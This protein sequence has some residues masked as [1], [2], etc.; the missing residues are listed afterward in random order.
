VRASTLAASGGAHGR[1]KN[2]TPRFSEGRRAAGA[3]GR[4]HGDGPD[5]LQREETDGQ[6]AAAAAEPEVWLT[7]NATEAEFIKA[8]VRHLIPADD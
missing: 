4:R 7:L 8:A 2:P 6:A 5:G 3:R 1:R